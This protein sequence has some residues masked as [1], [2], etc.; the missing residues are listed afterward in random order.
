M[1]SFSSRTF[2]AIEAVLYIALKTGTEPVRSR[3]IC[4]YQGV[5]VRYLEPL[6]Q[7]LVKAQ[8]LR[9]VRGPKGGYF[10][11]RERRKINL[12][13]I[14]DVV[15]GLSKKALPPESALRTQITAPIWGESKQLIL[16]RYQEITLADLCEKALRAGIQ[17]DAGKK[18]DFTI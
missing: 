18:S 8:I 15:S 5:A 7:R 14:I 3:D 2:H 4:D 10:L 16:K 9:G 17:I 12:A 11:A 13:E 1:D 6:L